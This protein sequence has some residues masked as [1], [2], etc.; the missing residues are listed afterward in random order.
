[1]QTSPR[2]DTRWP[3]NA[4]WSA[5]PK[6][7][8]ILITGGS[9]G[10][11]GALTDLY[12]SSGWRVLICAR[13]A[14][15]LEAVQNR[16]P[17][18][19]TVQ[20]DLGTTEGRYHLAEVVREAGR[21]DGLINNAA[22]QYSYPLAADAHRLEELQKEVEV[23]LIAPLALCHLLVGTLVAHRGFI[24]NVSSEVAYVPRAR[25]PVY[26]ATKAALSMYTRSVR[27]Q[28]PGLK[29]VEIIL[30]LV[31]TRMTAGRGQNKM[32]AAEAARQ[33]KAGLDAGQDTVRVGKTRLLPTLLRVVPALAVYLMNRGDPMYASAVPRG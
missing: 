1:M 32:S 11:G 14:E 24:A 18:A 33:I 13:N 26:C 6:T 3:D 4:V 12:V 8:T 10:V 25:S 2:A 16:H 5:R 15:G 29:V 28:N 23:N 22:I 19:K 21:L 9:Y 20:A 7:K 30:P 17:S 31:D 27:L